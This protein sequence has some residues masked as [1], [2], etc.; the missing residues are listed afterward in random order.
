VCW[1]SVHEEARLER[2]TEISSG[3]RV[4]HSERIGAEAEWGPPLRVVALL[5]DTGLM[6]GLLGPEAL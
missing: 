1:Y 2:L 6:D 4:D 5:G 3:W